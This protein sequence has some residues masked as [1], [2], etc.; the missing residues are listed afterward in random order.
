MGPLHS[1]FQPNTLRYVSTT[2]P[3]VSVIDRQT[4]RKKDVQIELD[5]LK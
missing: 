5:I 2:F 1:T 3:S 4:G